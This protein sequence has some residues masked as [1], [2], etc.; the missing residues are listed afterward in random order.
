MNDGLS[1]VVAEHPEPRDFPRQHLRVRLPVRPRH[2]EKNEKARAYR[3]RDLPLHRHARLADP[4]HNSPHM[5]ILS[6]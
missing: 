4:L 2:A 5:Y 6:C 1:R 3:P